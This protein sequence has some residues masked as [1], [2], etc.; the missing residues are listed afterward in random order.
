MNGTL[1]MNNITNI[2]D[3]VRSDSS[4]VNKMYVDDK[5]SKI[6]IYENLHFKSIKRT[7]V[8]SQVILSGNPFYIQIPKQ[9]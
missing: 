8:W 5:S 7:T 4:I 9:Y 1:N 6:T 3:L 2:S